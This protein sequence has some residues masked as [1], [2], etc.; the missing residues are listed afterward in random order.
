MEGLIDIR[1]DERERLPE[2]RKPAHV[3]VLGPGLGAMNRGYRTLVCAFE[4]SLDQDD[5]R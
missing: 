4:S 5:K 1:H 2:S 3:T